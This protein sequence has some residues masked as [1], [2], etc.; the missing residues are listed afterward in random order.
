[1]CLCTVTKKF[2]GRAPRLLEPIVRR[3]G[4]PG[5]DVKTEGRGYKVF[6][7]YR[8]HAGNI[9][10][11]YYGDVKFQ[12][13]K[14]LQAVPRDREADTGTEYETGFHIYPD[15]ISARMD[16]CH[17]ALYPVIYEVA[18]RDVICEGTQGGRRV[19]VARQMK[20]LGEVT[21]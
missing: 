1:M 7:H 18:Y 4:F 16:S 8:P 13:G 20:V 17:S 19:I 6:I 15:L 5:R 11:Q 12:V 3:V 10:F 14:W 21:G 2:C 9:G